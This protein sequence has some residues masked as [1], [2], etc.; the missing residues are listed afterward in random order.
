MKV[1]TDSVLLGA[2]VQSSNP[3][4]ILDIG[5]GTGLLSLMMAQRFS[6]ASIQGIEID[7][8]ALID[9]RRNVSHSDWEDRIELIQDDF[10]THVFNQ[11]FDLIISNPPYFPADTASPDSKRVLARKGQS[12]FVYNGLVKARTLLNDTGKIAMILP[13]DMWNNLEVQLESIGLFKTRIRFVKPKEDKL[14]HRILLELSSNKLDCIEEETLIIEKVKRHDYSSE[15]IDLT[16][17]FYLD[18]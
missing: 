3:K 17:A 11:K 2:W 15:Y 10:I 13:V 18:K 4:S 12:D 14:V 5:S 7:S 16:S 9:A 6:K 8:D 1:G